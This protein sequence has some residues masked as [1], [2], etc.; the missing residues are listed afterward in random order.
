MLPAAFA[1][2]IGQGGIVPLSGAAP[3]PF[4]AILR[5]DAVRGVP[6]GLVLA[7]KAGGR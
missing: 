5:G 7:T 3:V 2:I 1:D 4:G 6:C